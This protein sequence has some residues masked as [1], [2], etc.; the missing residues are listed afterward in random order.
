MNSSTDLKDTN[1]TDLSFFKD[2]PKFPKLYNSHSSSQIN[3]TS[4][5]IKH[6]SHK[7]KPSFIRLIKFNNNNNKPKYLFSTNS[8]NKSIL[9]TSSFNNNIKPKLNTSNISNSNTNTSILPFNHSKPRFTSLSSFKHIKHKLNESLS[10]LNPFETSN[11][12]T[13]NNNTSLFLSRKYQEKTSGSNIEMLK[14][15]HP[16][17]LSV[18]NFRNKVMSNGLNGTTQQQISNAKESYNSILEQI[19]LHHNNEILRLK[20]ISKRFNQ[21]KSF[22][23]PIYSIKKSSFNIKKNKINNTNKHLLKPIS[24]EYIKERLACI[25]ELKLKRIKH[26][27]KVFADSFKSIISQYQDISNYDKQMYPMNIHYQNLFRKIQTMLIQEKF[28]N[29]HD[30]DLC[31]NDPNMVRQF[32]YD[33]S[34]E[35]INRIACMEHRALKKKH[36][37]N[38]TLIKYNGLNGKLFGMPV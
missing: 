10:N 34:Q 13:N 17:H 6:L 31:E 15:E 2:I 37:K 3:P 16:H 21:T 35:V 4:S 33:V 23:N 32:G 1:T 29:I 24:E 26:K 36:F 12:S 28:Y 7:S 27:G 20:N 18:N 19:E 38:K 14:P 22:F 5:L 8:R 11:P 9:S 30:D 25:N